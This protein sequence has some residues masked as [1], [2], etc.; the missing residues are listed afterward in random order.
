MCQHQ[1]IKITNE[2]KILEVGKTSEIIAT[3]LGLWNTL[4]IL[5]TSSNLTLTD[6]DEDRNFH[7]LS[8]RG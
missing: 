2:L 3:L 4:K 7:S 5:W 1:Y 8:V 6:V